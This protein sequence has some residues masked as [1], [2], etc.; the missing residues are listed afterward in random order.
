MGNHLRL[1]CLKFETR[2]RARNACN[3]QTKRGTVQ[4]PRE[5]VAKKKH[6]A[7]QNIMLIHVFYL[8]FLNIAGMK[9][10]TAERKKMARCLRDALHLVRLRIQEAETTRKKF[11]WEAQP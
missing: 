5:K 4:S 8:I 1:H 2:N 3:F 6:S 11:H 7:I 10:H 9:F